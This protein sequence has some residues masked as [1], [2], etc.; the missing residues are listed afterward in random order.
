MCNYCVPIIN[1]LK[2]GDCMEERYTC[3]QVADLYHVKIRTVW[4]WIREKRLSG[5][6][7]G[8]TY[9]IRKED[10]EQFESNRLTISDEVK[11]TGG[12]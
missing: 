4:K 3:Q 6:K 9:V 8:K 11:K 2:G 5:I 12:I 10:L 1:N 7:L